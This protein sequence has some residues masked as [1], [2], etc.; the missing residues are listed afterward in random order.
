VLSV[1]QLSHQ[2]VTTGLMSRHHRMTTPCHHPAHKTPKPSGQNNLPNYLSC[3]VDF[4]E[5]V[6]T[7][8][9]RRI[10]LSKQRLGLTATVHDARHNFPTDSSLIWRRRSEQWPDDHVAGRSNQSTSRHCYVPADIL[11]ATDVVTVLK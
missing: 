6:V 1:L 7:T 10:A 4:Y 8:C 11:L 9:Y 5:M 2:Q 3:D